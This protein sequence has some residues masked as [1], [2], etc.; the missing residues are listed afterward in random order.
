M[1]KLDA[2]VDMQLQQ[3][4]QWWSGELLSLVPPPL[5]KLLGSAGE[6][7]ILDRDARGLTVTHR[8]G[9]QSMPLVHLPLEEDGNT[10]R[11]RF[12][13]D[14]PDLEGIRIALRLNAQE[15][16]RKRIKLPLAAAENLQQVL[17]FEMDRMT[18]FKSDQVYF[19]AQ[20][21]ERL[22][23]TR[24][25]VVDLVLTPRGKL[26]T[27]LDTLAEAGWRPDLVFL[28][29][30]SK[31]GACN[32]LPL[33]LAPPRDRLPQMLNI[34]LAGALLTLL[35]LLAIL[36]IW[37]ARSESLHLQSAVNKTGKV[38]R[39]V[40]AMREE[41]DKLLHQAQF[42]QEKKQTEPV[43][44]DTLEELSRVIPDGTWLNGLQFTNRRVVIQGQSPSASSLLQ[45]IESSAYFRNV[46]FSSP[47]TKDSTN[48][49]ERFQVAADA[50]N[51]RFS[52][53]PD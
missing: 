38:A 1:L 17:T 22:K 24:Q 16:L 49:L 9:T 27:I 42:L 41:A 21:V 6:C 8:L 43:L 45:S 47:V 51:G 4:W 40:E 28:E 30:D 44:S 11:Q 48:G 20:I 10:V 31:P 26:E 14:H 39:E 32:L 37:S 53:K 15:G 3:F 12:L 5:Q 52:E 23:A 13:A 19:S 2:P 36:P 35:A 25:I 50:V 46:S 29:G 34:G 33:H 7:L 18:P